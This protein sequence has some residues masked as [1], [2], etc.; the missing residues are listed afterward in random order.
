VYGANQHEKRTGLRFRK[1]RVVIEGDYAELGV[2]VIIAAGC[3][4]GAEWHT[5]LA[6]MHNL[7]E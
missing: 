1:K 6:R 2:T 5:T 3:P 4:F 7:G